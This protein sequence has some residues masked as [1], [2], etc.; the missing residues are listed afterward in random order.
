MRALLVS[1][2][3]P[4]ETGWGGIGTYVD[5][6]AP[7]LVRAGAEVHVLSVAPDQARGRTRRPDGVVVHRAPLMRLRGPGRVTGLPH[8]WRRLRSAV[9]VDREIRRLGIHFDV[10]ECPDWNA[11]GFVLARTRRAPLV[12]R[13]HSSAAQVLPFVG[14]RRCDARLAAWMEDDAMRRADLVTGTSA[15]LAAEGPRAGIPDDRLRLISC[16]VAPPGR[17]G[18]APHPSRICFVGRFEARKG[19]D[20]VVRALP[21]VRVKLPGAHL[22]MLGRDMHDAGHPSFVA[23]L[24]SLA[25]ELG[26]AEAVEIR[27]RWAAREEVVAAMASS[28]VCVAPSRWESFGLVAAEAASLGRPVVASDIPGFHDAVIDGET[29]RLVPAD[30]P[31]AWGEALVELLTDPPRAVAMG[32]AGARHVERH[33]HP[34]RVAALTLDAYEHAIARSNGSRGAEPASKAST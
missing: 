31:G 9:S 6:L 19:P 28:A 11:E 5:T 23:F 20:T 13:S 32:R 30:D 21:A 26:V 10:I 1:Q 25:A 16:P 15:Q 17:R 7:A 8:T 34:D 27:D 3:L 12:V 29:G 33:C 2:E 24:R 22:V 14:P 18:E 4:P